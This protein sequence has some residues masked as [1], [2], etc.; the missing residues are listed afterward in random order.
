MSNAYDYMTSRQFNQARLYCVWPG[1]YAITGSHSGRWTPLLN[2]QNFGHKFASLWWIS[3]FKAKASIHQR[4]KLQHNDYSQSYRQYLGWQKF[5]TGP[6]LYPKLSKFRNETWR[7]WYSG[8]SRRCSQG[9]EFSTKLVPCMY[10]L[11]MLPSCMSAFAYIHTA[12]LP[13]ST[14]YF[15]HKP[16]Y[17]NEF[18]MGWRIG[19][20]ELI[21]DNL[22]EYRGHTNPSVCTMPL[23]GEYKARGS[24][25][26]LP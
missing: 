13:N 6:G 9:W 15:A 19:Q 7:Y 20:F 11:Y 25:H 8:T 10:R 26:R 3:G 2:G 4:W 14:H 21:T 18:F 23:P 5:T 12:I 17:R 22:Y 1:Q 16:T 24:N